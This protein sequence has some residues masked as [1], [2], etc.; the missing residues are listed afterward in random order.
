MILRRL[1]I[2]ILQ[3]FLLA[4]GR[5]YNREKQE[6]AKYSLREKEESRQFSDSISRYRLKVEAETGR[7]IAFSENELVKDGAETNLGNF[8]CDALM[9]AAETK[10]T[11]E[12]MDAV[13]LNRGG[14]RASLPKGEIKVGHIFELMPFE[15]EMVI[16]TIKGSELFK[17]LALLPEKKHPFSG[18][19]VKIEKE[20]LKEVTINGAEIDR[21]KNYRIITSDYLAGGGDGFTFFVGAPVKSSGQKIRDAIIEYCE[22]LSSRK[23]TVKAYTDGRL[24]I[25]K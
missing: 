23:Q 21:E 24:E 16:L 6:F 15:N 3:L 20:Q 14:L 18:F 25:S 13:I 12:K 5:H 11:G 1:A 2:V 19:K 22:Y 10:F 7:V 4:C 17:F 8:V 9:H